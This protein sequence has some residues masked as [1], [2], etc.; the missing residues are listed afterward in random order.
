MILTDPVEPISEPAVAKHYPWSVSMMLIGDP[1]DFCEK[2][3]STRILQV[4]R[5]V[6]W[7]VCPF[8]LKLKRDALDYFSSK[9]DGNFGYA[10]FEVNPGLPPVVITRANGDVVEGRFTGALAGGFIEVGFG[11]KYF[12][13]MN[14]QSV[15]LRNP[16]FRFRKAFKPYGPRSDNVLTSLDSLN[17]LE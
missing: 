15:W 17:G 7:P 4:T 11:E 5:A 13:Y 8:C 16:W 6:G 3:P 2:N 9:Y 10:R 12:K 1:C 14:P